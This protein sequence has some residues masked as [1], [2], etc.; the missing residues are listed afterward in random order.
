MQIHQVK[1]SREGRVLIPSSVRAL[2]GLTDGASLNLAV[3]NGEIRLFDQSV[4]L[5][6]ARNITAKYKSPKKSVV[7][8]LIADRRAQAGSE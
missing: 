5:K 1:L 7:E 4:A 8:E 6:R 3:E 2:L